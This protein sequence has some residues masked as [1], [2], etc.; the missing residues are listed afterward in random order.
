[1]KPPLVPLH[2]WTPDVYEGVAPA[3]TGFL[4]SIGKT[5]VVVV[6]LRLLLASDAH[7]RAPVMLVL[8]GVC[9]A[10][11]AGRQSARPVPA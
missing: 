9:G 5:A 10:V 3:V 11:D 8:A 6:L 2:W 4:V 1:M 7:A